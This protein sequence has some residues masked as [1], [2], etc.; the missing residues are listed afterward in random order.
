MNQYASAIA[1]KLNLRTIHV[2]AVLQ[3]FDEGGTVP[4]IARYRKDKT[5][6]MDEVAIQQVQDEAKRLAEFDERKAAIVKS[7]TEQGKMT[8]AIME[9]LDKAATLS[10]LEDIYLPFKPKRKTKASVAREHGLEPLALLLLEQQS[11]TDPVQEAQAFI[12]EHV[13]STDEALQGAR[14]ILAEKFSEDA[15]IR[16]AVRR[17][18]EDKADL[19]SRLIP[20]KE[21]EA[22]KFR[23]YFE[24]SEPIHKI[25]SH[26]ILAVLRG[27]LEGFLRISIEPAEQDALDL[28]ERK[29]LTASND[30]SVHVKKAIRD[31]YKRLLQPGLETEMRTTLKQRG[32]EEAINVFAENLR[33]LLLSSPLGGKRLLAL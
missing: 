17:L 31:S 28:L 22:A 12:N 33:Q 3:L 32:D 13:K 24:Y 4:F 1:G 14:D 30:A 27:F 6:A 5:G 11:G 16:A 10:E 19:A 15:D 29:I 25:P 9:K 23:D 18:F 20:E 7:I 2:E 21:T 8:E 26:R